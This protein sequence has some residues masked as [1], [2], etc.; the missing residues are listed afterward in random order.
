M[1]QAEKAEIEIQLKEKEEKIQQLSKLL[2]FSSKASVLAIESVPSDKR[3]QVG[4]F[5]ILIKK[6]LFS[7]I[8]SEPKRNLVYWTS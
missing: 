5:F 1:L 3:V 2:C 8:D 6:N 7:C 4:I